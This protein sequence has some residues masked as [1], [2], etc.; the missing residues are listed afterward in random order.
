[1]NVASIAVVIYL[2]RF[3]PKF[4]NCSKDTVNTDVQNEAFRE[5]VY[6]DVQTSPSSSGVNLG[7]HN[8]G[9]YEELHHPGKDEDNHVYQPLKN[10][11]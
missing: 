1:M 3:H 7:D 6:D 2:S 9:T 5:D 10:T 11:T 4:Q 8:P